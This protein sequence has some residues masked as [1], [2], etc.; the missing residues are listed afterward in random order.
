M[1]ASMA[2]VW[3]MTRGNI[4]TVT[5]TLAGQGQTVAQTASVMGTACVKMGQEN[6]TCV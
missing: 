3:T 6:V 2:C 4:F 1:T 5:V